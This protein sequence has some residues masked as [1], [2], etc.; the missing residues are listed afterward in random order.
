MKKPRKHETTRSQKATHKT[1]NPTPLKWQYYHYQPYFGLQ[2]ELSRASSSSS[3]TKTP[4]TLLPSHFT[5]L[6]TERERE[7]DCD[8]RAAEIQRNKERSQTQ[9][10]LPFAASNKCPNLFCTALLCMK[11][12]RLRINA[13]R[14]CSVLYCVV[15]L[16]LDWC[17]YACSLNWGTICF[18]LLSLSLCSISCLVL[19]MV[20]VKWN[21]SG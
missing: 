3:V 12:S 18:F 19:L 20:D 4:H 11:S 16:E 6:L 10:R 7:R 8:L 15:L 21:R 5:S 14:F 1:Q 2:L 9:V 13:L 17:R